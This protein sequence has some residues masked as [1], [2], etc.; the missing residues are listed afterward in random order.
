M[1]APSGWYDDPEDSTHLRY[2]DG[3][4]W[5][6]HRTPKD[7]PAPPAPVT[8]PIAPGA[9]APGAGG[10]YGSGYGSGYGQPPAGQQPPMQQPGMG[11]QPGIGQP[12]SYGGSPTAPGGYGGYPGGPAPQIPGQPYPTAPG[13]PPGS[14]PP[15]GAPGMPHAF[16]GPTTRDGV[17]LASLGA[18]L[19]ARV[20][21]WLI[22]TV[23]VVAAAWSQLSTIFTYYGNL[24][25]TLVQQ[26]DAG[27]NPVMP[28][29]SEIVNAIGT[30]ILQ[31]TIIV[32]VIG[33]LYETFFLAISGAT[34]GK[35]LLGLRVRLAERPGRPPVGSVLLRELIWAANWVPVVSYVAWL[36]NILDALW[37]IWDGNRQALH[38]RMAKTQV[39]TTR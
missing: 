31:V 18:R 9:P 23:L 28:A 13:Y 1:S 22:L 38:D 39:V 21:D 34:P 15:A 32:L 37:P 19:G 14:W 17:R 3:V 27:Q 36:V 6:Q 5:T 7:P 20:V 10:G 16:A 2:W 8:P 25:D 11:Q 33:L 29:T 35:R 12:P 30:P 4:V 26:T 24:V